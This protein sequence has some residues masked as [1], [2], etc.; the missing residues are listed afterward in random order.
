MASSRYF[1]TSWVLVVAASFGLNV[2][3]PSK[4]SATSVYI[5]SF[6]GS[7]ISYV[8]SPPVEVGNTLSGSFDIPVSDFTGPTTDGSMITIP[9]A[10]IIALNFTI[11][12]YGISPNPSGVA[13]LGLN[14]LITSPSGISLIFTYLSGLPQVTSTNNGYPLAQL[15]DGSAGFGETCCVVPFVFYPAE[16]GSAYTDDAGTWTTTQGDLSAT[17]LP[18]ALPLFA[19]GLGVMGAF[20]W[21]R[22]RKAAAIAA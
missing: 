10:D 18:A 14:D 3:W 6:S 12:Y 2:A 13:T 17:P 5:F 11:D 8:G 22:K 19:G 7:N 15:P 1:I 9:N 20:R 16:Y 4:A 21:R